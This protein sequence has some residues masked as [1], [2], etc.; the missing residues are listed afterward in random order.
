MPTELSVALEICLLGGKKGAS[1]VPKYDSKF[2]N[3]T[4]LANHTCLGATPKAYLYPSLSIELEILMISLPI[5]SIRSLYKYWH[6]L[7]LVSH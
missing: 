5:S 4:F 7:F 2:S 1:D 6:S 3:N